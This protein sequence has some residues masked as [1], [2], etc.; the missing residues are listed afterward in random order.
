[1]AGAKDAI[2]A[3]AVYLLLTFGSFFSAAVEDEAV[4]SKYQDICAEEG[5]EMSTVILVRRY[6][7]YYTK[8]SCVKI[9]FPEP[10]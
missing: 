6:I 4:I 5:G 2:A 9:I 1:M 8:E 3:S 7:F 10:R